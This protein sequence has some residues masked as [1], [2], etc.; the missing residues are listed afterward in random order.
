[1]KLPMI[2]LGIPQVSRR[3]VKD[4]Q[5]LMRLSSL[6]SSSCLFAPRELAVIAT[7]AGVVINGL[8]R[9]TQDVSTAFWLESNATC[10]YFCRARHQNQARKSRVV[11][12]PNS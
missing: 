7:A 4:R 8:Y 3:M 12:P 9:R 5:Q 10:P 1:M 6:G 11:L 2:M